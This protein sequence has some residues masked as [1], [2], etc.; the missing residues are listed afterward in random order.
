M[1]RTETQMNMF[2]AKAYLRDEDPTDDVLDYNTHISRKKNQ[3]TTQAS[4][5]KALK[6]HDGGIMRKSGPLYQHRSLALIEEN[7]LRNIGMM[8]LPSTQQ[9]ITILQG[10]SMNK[11]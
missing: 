5:V 6:S 2:K 7:T 4:P 9:A 3:K 8:N 11:G 10:D 1:H